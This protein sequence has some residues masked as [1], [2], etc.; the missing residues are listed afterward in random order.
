MAKPRLILA[1]GSVIRARILKGAGIEFTVAKPGVDE[2]AI[3]NTMERSG[4]SLEETAQALADAKALAVEAEPDD[5]V[6]GSDQI[7]EFEGR[8]FDKPKNIAEA[9]ARL[10]KLQGA[11]H[12]LINGVAIAKAGQIVFQNIDRPRLTMRPLTEADLDAYFAA[13]DP[14]I[15]NSV[16]A[17]QIE[18]LGARLFSKIDG[19]YFAV[20]G[21][22][23]FPVLAF[24]R[25]E[26]VIEF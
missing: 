7:M 18:E 10:L 5:Y 11:E 8:G 22:S 4:A 13:A 2:D 3:K 19:D 16:G 25:R 1:S 21:L 14:D 20:L 23:L 17:Y 12:S 15:L 26:R 6:L 24:L 9:R